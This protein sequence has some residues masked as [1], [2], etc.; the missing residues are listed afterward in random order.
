VATG[1]KA[2]ANG[3][4]EVRALR[5]CNIS[6]NSTQRGMRKISRGAH[7]HLSGKARRRRRRGHGRRR[8]AAQS[9]RHVVG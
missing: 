4:K 8:G 1:R 3:G 6:K 7:D 9:P 5:A 2:H